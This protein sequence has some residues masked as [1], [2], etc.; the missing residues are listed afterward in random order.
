MIKAFVVLRN[1]PYSVRAAISHPE[2]LPA[3]TALVVGHRGLNI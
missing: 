2:A 1:Y 3:V